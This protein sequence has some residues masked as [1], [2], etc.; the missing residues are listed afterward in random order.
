MSLLGF[1]RQCD[2]R[3][4]FFLGAK[5]LAAWRPPIDEKGD[6]DSEDFQPWNCCQNCR[7][8]RQDLPG[9]LCVTLGQRCFL[10]LVWELRL[11][12]SPFHVGWGNWSSLPF[13]WLKRPVLKMVSLVPTISKCSLAAVQEIYKG[14]STKE[15]LSGHILFDDVLPGLLP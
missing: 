4:S 8:G 10:W 5:R 2:P 1:Q 9:L 3:G 6:S 7:L 12:P 14:R 11:S 15:A 13:V